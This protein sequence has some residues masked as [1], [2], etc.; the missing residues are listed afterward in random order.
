M[1]INEE[2]LIMG[3]KPY[4]YH[5]DG[6]EWGKIP[7]DW[8][9]KEATAVAVNSNDEVIVFNRGTKPIIVVDT[10]GNYLNSWGENI[11][12][13]AH[14]ISVD[15]KNNIYC[16][17]SGDNTVRKFDSYGKLIFQIGKE[18]EKAEK[19]SGLPFAVPTQV[20]IDS[21]NQDLYVADGYS[22]AKVHKYNKDGKYLFSWGESGT[23]EG[24]F[25]IVH[26][27]STDSEGLVY[28]ADRENHRIQV[29]D[30]NGN[31]LDQ[32]INLSRAAC[33][34]IDKRGK[35]DI[36]YVGEYFSGIASNDIGINLG[37]RISIFNKSG[38]LLSR[39]GIDSYGPS[40]G[41]FYSPHG[42][43]VDSKGNIFVAEVSYSD[44]GQFMNP[45]REL[46]SLQK[47]TKI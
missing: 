10:D 11:F 24:Q 27:I 17:D 38:E 3:T 21:N 47:L 25:N 16:V 6:K 9:L 7:N 42:I 30:K 39:V 14:G 32:W 45:K 44:Y 28:V 41:R 2:S 18:G 20:A 34:Y 8:T 5:V 15:D 26:N 13:N 12:T 22:N 36:F 40:T 1:A 33:L 35:E 43:S 23:G 29:F 4:S 31:Y 46:R 19:M 37:P